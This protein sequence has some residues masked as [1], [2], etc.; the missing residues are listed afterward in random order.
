M[1]RS[2]SLFGVLFASGSYRKYVY[3]KLERPVRLGSCLIW[4][5]QSLLFYGDPCEDG[6]MSFWP[7]RV[8]VCSVLARVDIHRRFMCW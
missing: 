4:S 2:I 8:R 5:F 1:D 6:E 7:P 3:S